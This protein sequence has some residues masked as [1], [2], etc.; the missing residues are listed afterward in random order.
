[1]L[2]MWLFLWFCSNWLCVCLR[3]CLWISC[4][5]LLCEKCWNLLSSVCIGMLVVSVILVS[6]I[7][8]YVC[9]LI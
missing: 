6:V 8:L 1:M 5:G 9:L 7:G 3:C 4:I 2:V